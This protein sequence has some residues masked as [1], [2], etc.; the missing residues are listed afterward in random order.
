[1][2]LFSAVTQEE[3]QAAR[4]VTGLVMALFVGIS[5]VPGLRKHASALRSVLLAAYL[6]VCAVFVAVVL[7]R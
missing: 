6:L 3:M 5:V 1:M 7:L 2:T 4:I